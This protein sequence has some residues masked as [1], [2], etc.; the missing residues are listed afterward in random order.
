M[1][2]FLFFNFLWKL[3]ISET[4][5]K[6]N[7]GL[8]DN[9]YRGSHFDRRSESCECLYTISVIFASYLLFLYAPV[10]LGVV[11]MKNHLIKEVTNIVWANVN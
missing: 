3:S 7:L 11:G 6:H 9:F 5:I 10:N 4:R 2:C 1:V 8:L